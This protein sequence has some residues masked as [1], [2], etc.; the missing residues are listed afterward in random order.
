MTHPAE[1]KS[2]GD[3]KK[4]SPKEG[5]IKRIL[6]DKKVINKFLKGDASINDLDARGIKFVKP[7]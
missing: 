7:L 2:N 3:V 4:L 6:D 5:L 1:N